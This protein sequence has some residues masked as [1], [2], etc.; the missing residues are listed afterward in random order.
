LI[1]NFRW[2]KQEVCNTAIDKGVRVDQVN[3]SGLTPLQIA[4]KNNNFGNVI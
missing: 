3:S 1:N 2:N 4:G